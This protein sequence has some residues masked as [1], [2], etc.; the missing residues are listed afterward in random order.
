MRIF[1]Q[2]K[3]LPYQ[4]YILL[5]ARIIS[6]IGMFV[7]PFLTLFL[8][9]R[10][11]FSELDIGKF[12]LIITLTY[13][14][15]AIVGGKLADRFNRRPVYLI[16]MLCSNIALLG[17]GFFTDSIVIIYFLLVAFFFMNMSQ[18]VL[19]AMMM[20]LT[21]PDNRQESF[22][23]VY[24]GINIGGAIGPMAAGFMFENHTRWIFWGEAILNLLALFLIFAFIKETKPDEEDLERITHD[25][26][27]IS[28]AASN[29]SLIAVLIRSPIVIS[30]AF[31]AS[32][33][34]FSYSQVSFML[35]LQM[36]EIF[37]IS[38]GA[39]CYG[40]LISLNCIIVVIATPILVLVTKKFAAL[41]NLGISGILFMFGLGLYGIAEHL[42]FF[43]VLSAIWTFGEILFAT[44]T[45]VYI[46]NNSPITHRA[47]FQSIFD[48]IQG[49]GRAVGPLT[50]GYFLIDHTIPQAW[51][52][53]GFLCFLAAVA[54][55]ALNVIERRRLKHHDPAD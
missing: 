29:E 23:L 41:S 48:I 6:A 1:N 3:G 13:I 40:M 43:Y 26:I 22:S 52:L 15:A 38:I 36:E 12:L 55:F 44:N 16:S 10:L 39:K 42:Y 28:E 4:I 2:Y 17:A 33:L 34:A 7:Y 47:R 53:V 8:S 27:R 50:I 5:L 45:G 18:P 32:L 54:L 19:A 31:C 49:T 9:S 30:F 25:A 21:A 37:G 20:D 35:P 14:P 11:G 51:F 46:A 24:L